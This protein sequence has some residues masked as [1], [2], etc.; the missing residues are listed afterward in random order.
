MSSHVSSPHDTLACTINRGAHGGSPDP[1]TKYYNDMAHLVAARMAILASKG[2]MILVEQPLMTFLYFFKVFLGFIGAPGVVLFREDD[3]M[4]GTP[5]M[6]P[7][8]WITTCPSIAAGT[9][10]VC[11]HPGPHPERLEGAKARQSAP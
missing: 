1:E 8:A 4:Y 2:A 10:R 9:A 7:R 11:A 5:Y 3:C 6:K